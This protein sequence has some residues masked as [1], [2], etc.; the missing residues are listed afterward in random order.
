MQGAKGE[1]VY[2]PRGADGERFNNNTS[3]QSP[4]NFHSIQQTLQ[5][6]LLDVLV[7]VDYLHYVVVVALARSRGV[8]E[9]LAT[10][11][12]LPV[13]WDLMPLCELVVRRQDTLE[14]ILRRR[15]VVCH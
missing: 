10:S 4:S 8:H 11:S 14:V 6:N 13:L 5:T 3:R 12:C 7:V 1:E 15:N 9:L 2:K